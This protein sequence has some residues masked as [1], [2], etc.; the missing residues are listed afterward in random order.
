MVFAAA[1]SAGV[2][3]SEAASS[4]DVPVVTLTFDDNPKGHLS[5]AAPVLERYGFRGTFNI[6]CDWVGMDARRMTWDDIRE[7]RRRG[8][9]IASHTLWHKS[10]VKQFAQEGADAV[11]S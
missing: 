5:I 11:K 10:L 8:H 2:Q 1:V 6:V 7:L 3:I 4:A 9:E